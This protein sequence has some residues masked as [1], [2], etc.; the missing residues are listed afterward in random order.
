MPGVRRVL[1]GG[2]GIGAKPVSLLH[3]TRVHAGNIARAQTAIW[4]MRRGSAVRVLLERA[5]LHRQF[6]LSDGNAGNGAVI[7]GEISGARSTRRAGASNHHRNAGSM[8]LEAEPMPPE[9][10]Q[11]G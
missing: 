3:G 7:V 9:L 2:S 1:V 6:R 11:A 4:N 5:A 8:P 10:E